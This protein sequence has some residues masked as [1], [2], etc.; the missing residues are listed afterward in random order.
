MADED[1][2]K[3]PNLKLVSE[4][5]SARADGQVAWAK[6]E[7]DRTLSLF[8]AALLRTMAGSNT[9]ATY[10]M[11]RLSDFTHAVSKFRVAS[12]QN[13]RIADWRRCFAY[14]SRRMTHRTMIVPATL[15]P[16]RRNGDNRE[17]CI[18]ASG[19]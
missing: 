3:P 7:V 2:G 15:A 14:R 13:L 18:A 9:E 11:R 12:G 5:S 1:D 4:N 17:G 10:L 6:D 8:A 19:P 16:R